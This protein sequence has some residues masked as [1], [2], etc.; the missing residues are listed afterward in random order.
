MFDPGA[1]ARE[2]KFKE[3]V[4]LNFKTLYLLSEIKSS[5]ILTII[6]IVC[7]IKYMFDL[8]SVYGLRILGSKLI[9]NII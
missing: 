9:V 3:K 7:F 6:L 5:V 4:R 1:P 8:R 2:G